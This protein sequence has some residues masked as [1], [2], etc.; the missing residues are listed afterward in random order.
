M[1]HTDY[2]KSGIKEGQTTRQNTAIPQ[3]IKTQLCI[4]FPGGAD[5]IQLTCCQ[6]QSDQLI[7]IL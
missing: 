2:Y 3:I 4:F 7:K 1:W 6:E 5:C